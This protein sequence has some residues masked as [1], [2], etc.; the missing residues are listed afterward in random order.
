MLQ[1]KQTLFLLAAMILIFFNLFNPFVGNEQLVFNSFKIE[2]LGIDNPI[3]INTY[4]IAIY[5]IVLTAAHLFTIFLFKSRPLQMRFTML[6]LFL[7]VGFYGILLFYHFLANRQLTIEFNQYSFGL[8]SVLLAAV[9]DY[10]AYSGIK[11]DEKL[12]KDSERFR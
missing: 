10:M 6:S 3:K 12:V 8:V 11:K 5:I 4:P 7:S 2:Q 1:R 9:F